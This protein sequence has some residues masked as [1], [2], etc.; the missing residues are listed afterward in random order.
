[1]STYN[2]EP[3]DTKEP[4]PEGVALKAFAKTSGDTAGVVWV[5]EDGGFTLWRNK[6]CIGT[7]DTLKALYKKLDKID[8]G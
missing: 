3:Y 7:F 1:M 5:L 4:L 8:L 2:L 6:S